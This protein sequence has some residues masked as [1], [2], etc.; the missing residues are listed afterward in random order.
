MKE[1]NNTCL[2]NIWKVSDKK[3]SLPEGGLFLEINYLI[4]HLENTSLLL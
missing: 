3:A 1:E 4:F 2:K